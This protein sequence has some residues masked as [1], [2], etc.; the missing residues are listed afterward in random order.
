[1]KCERERAHQRHHL[2]TYDAT[3]AA[4]SHL[5][6]N[7]LLTSSV[8]IPPQDTHT[9]EILRILTSKFPQG[10][11]PAVTLIGTDTKL[12]HRQ[13]AEKTQ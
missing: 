7:G 1:M 12:D 13:K 5:H 8:F 4:R 6:C 10:N 11:I 9:S 3:G 2:S